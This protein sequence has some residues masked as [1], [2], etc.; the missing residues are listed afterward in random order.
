MKSG[1]L[2]FDELTEAEQEIVCWL[3]CRK[4]PPGYEAVSHEDL[5]INYVQTVEPRLTYDI[6]DDGPRRGQLTSDLPER[7]L[8]DQGTVY[9]PGS[10]DAIRDTLGSG[11]NAGT[12]ATFG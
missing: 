7:Y 3:S 8:I 5:D 2:G 10:G 11:F 9:T 6:S 12:Q 4:V 1:P